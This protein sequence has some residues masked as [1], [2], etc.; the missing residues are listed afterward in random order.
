MSVPVLG[1]LQVTLSPEKKDFSLIRK[2]TS[3]LDLSNPSLLDPAVLATKPGLSTADQLGMPMEP[4]NTIFEQDSPPTLN[5]HQQFISSNMSN[6]GTPDLAVIAAKFCTAQFSVSGKT[7]KYFHN[8][9]EQTRVIF[10]GK[11]RNTRKS[12]SYRSPDTR[13]NKRMV[14]A[15]V[16]MKGGYQILPGTTKLPPAPAAPTGY[17]KKK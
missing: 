17:R 11:G 5:Q 8:C 7:N 14:M 3:E 6:R 10:T 13:Q 2:Q 4:A 12:N 1:A 15:P 9:Q 16:P